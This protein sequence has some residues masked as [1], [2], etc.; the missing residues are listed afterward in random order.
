MTIPDFNSQ[1][2]QVVESALAQR[3]GQAVDLQLADSELKLDPGVPALTSCPTLYWHERGCHF[4][5]FKTAANRY[6]CQFFY[7]DDE[8]FGPGRAEYGD[9]NACVLDLL[10]AQADREKES[11]GVRSGLTGDQIGEPNDPES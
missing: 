5:V 1:E 10:R 4:L 3:F 6:R 7:T 2:R 8:H 11:K 9:L